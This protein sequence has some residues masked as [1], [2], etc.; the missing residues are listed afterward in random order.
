[1]KCYF[2]TKKNTF[3]QSGADMN[4]HDIHPG[5]CPEEKVESAK[6]LQRKWEITECKYWS[7]VARSD[8]GIDHRE[9]ECRSLEIC[10][11]DL[12]FDGE[13]FVGVYLPQIQKILPLRERSGIGIVTSREFVGG[14]GD[15]EKGVWY[16]LTLK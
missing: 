14:W 12:V 9:E 6:E 8:S 5:E 13:D 16:S 15:V 4:G 1:M 2:V 7:C 3:A 11:E 10:L